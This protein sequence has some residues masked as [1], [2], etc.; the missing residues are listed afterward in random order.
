[1]RRIL[2]GL[3][4]ASLGAASGGCK[5]PP[6]PQAQAAPAPQPVKMERVKAGVGVGKKGRSLDNERGVIVTPVKALFAAKEKIAYEIQFLGQYRIYRATNDVPKDF[7]DLTVKVLEPFMIKL[8]ELPAGHK[9]V[10]DA[11]TEELQVERPVP[12]E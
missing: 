4:T 5:P 3:L 7:D 8:P 6:P 10:W 9:Y 1:M 12:Q 2:I 11:E